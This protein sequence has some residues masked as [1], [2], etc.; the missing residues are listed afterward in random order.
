MIAIEPLAHF[1]AGFEKRHALLIDRHVRAGAWIASGASRPVLDR[2]CAKAPQLNAISA[3]QRVD[4]LVKNRVDDVLDIALIK[5]RIV[6]GD[7]LNEF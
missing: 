7:A 4:D 1:L 2:K 5:V 3:C 6:L